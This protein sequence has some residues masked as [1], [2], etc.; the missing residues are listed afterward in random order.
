M[1]C[2]LSIIWTAPF[3]STLYKIRGK[4]AQRG[5][6]FCYTYY[7]GKPCGIVTG[8]GCPSGPH[9]FRQHIPKSY[10]VLSTG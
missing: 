5:K 3:V 10:P 1:V 6:S 9:L 8:P 7:F 2:C 4:Y